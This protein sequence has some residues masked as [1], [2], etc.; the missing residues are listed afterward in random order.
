MQRQAKATVTGESSRTQRIGLIHG[1]Q[2]RRNV[3]AI[4]VF[5]KLGITVEDRPA[6]L[7]ERG[8]EIHIHCY[9]EY[10]VKAAI[11]TAPN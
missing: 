10:C 9:S 8:E 2:A 5:C 7:L 11:R 4:C 1:V 6:V 3:E